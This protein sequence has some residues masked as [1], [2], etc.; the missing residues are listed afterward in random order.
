MANEITRIKT[1]RGE[2]VLGHSKSFSPIIVRRKPSQSEGSS[3]DI[4]L[5]NTPHGIKLFVKILNKWFT[6][7]EEIKSIYTISNLTRNQDLDADGSLANLSDVVGT[8]LRDLAKQGL[9]T[10]NEN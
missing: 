1:S 3:G 4:A 10:V 6:A 9:I 8:L 5:G 2:R 7:E